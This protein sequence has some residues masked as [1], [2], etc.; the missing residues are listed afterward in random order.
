MM[1]AGV[2]QSRMH[3]FYLHGD[4]TKFVAYRGGVPR[5]THPRQRRPAL[6]RGA[7]D[8]PRLLRHVRVSRRPRD[9]PGPARRRRRMAA[10]R[11]RTA[12]LGPIDYS[13]NYHLRPAGRRL[14]HAAADHDE[15]QSALLRRAAGVLGP[16]QGQ[17]PYGWWF[18]DPTTWRSKWRERAERIDRARQDHRSA[19][20]HAGFRRRGATL[21]GGL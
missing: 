21:Q 9:G 8:Q 12:I 11:G 10:A 1:E 13:T 14:R 7:Q 2:P 5:G 19:L 17:G 18:D 3:P 15:P 6:Q 4:A 20:P 16:D